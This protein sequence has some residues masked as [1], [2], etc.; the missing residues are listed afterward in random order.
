MVYQLVN[1]TSNQ[2]TTRAD[3][4]PSTD[5][6]EPNQLNG[7]DTAEVLEALGLADAAI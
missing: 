4:E 6:E 2:A 1:P 5:P 3:P 7:F